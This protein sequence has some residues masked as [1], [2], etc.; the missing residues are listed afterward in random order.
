[1]ISEDRESLKDNKDFCKFF[2]CENDLKVQKFFG[3]GKKQ[4]GIPT[5]K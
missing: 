4:I 3:D 1:M 5:D 2:N